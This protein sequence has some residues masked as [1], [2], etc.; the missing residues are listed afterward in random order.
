MPWMLVAVLWVLWPAAVRAESEADWKVCNSDDDRAAIAACTRLIRDGGLSKKNYAV[1]YYNRGLS[2]RRLDE[3]DKAL[4][5]YTKAIGY[6][7][8]DPEIYNNRGVVYEAMENYDKAVADYSKAIQLDGEFIKAFTN[9]GETYAKMRAYDKAIADYEKATRIDA[10]EALAFGELAGLYVRDGRYDRAIA[11]GDTAIRL[12]DKFAG[13]YFARGVSRFYRGE[14]E[15]ASPDFRRAIDHDA[16]TGAMIY[17]HMAR[18]RRGEDAKSELEADA[19]RLTSREW[20]YAAIEF[21]IGKRTAGDMMA[22][23]ISD[24]EKCEASYYLAQWH[25][26]KGDQVQGVGELTN[27]AAR[28]P[29][30]EWERL[31]AREELKRLRP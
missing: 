26:A 17:R 25:L 7:P 21:F 15:A 11:S 23:A 3:N 19:G 24:V 22:A 14:H 27:A 5:D 20:P 30:S 13:A 28:C 8:D 10:K 1:A 18:L 6:T 16:A 29:D 9:R 2:Y 4:A 31:G 12:D